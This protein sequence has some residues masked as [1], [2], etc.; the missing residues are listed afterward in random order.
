[1]EE[2]LETAR[3]FDPQLAPLF[4][5]AEGETNPKRSRDRQTVESSFSCFGV[6][7]H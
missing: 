5:E 1:M 7:E 6:P 2:I 3:Q 4:V